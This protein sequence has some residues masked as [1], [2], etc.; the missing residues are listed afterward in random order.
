MQKLWPGA[1]FQLYFRAPLLYGML[2]AAAAAC[3]VSGCFEACGGGWSA[4]QAARGCC[5]VR[6]GA[7]RRGGKVFE[8]RRLQ[9]AARM[10]L[11]MRG[12]A[13]LSAQSWKL[14]VRRR[15]RRS[16]TVKENRFRFWF[17]ELL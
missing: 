7:G 10:C 6:G 17:T 14:F 8:R 5:E 11:R 13:A 9:S 3:S 2:R 4:R 16:V 15:A 1:P 12:G